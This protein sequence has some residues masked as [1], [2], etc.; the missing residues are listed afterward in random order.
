MPRSSKGVKQ[1]ECF[2]CDGWNDG[3][4]ANEIEKALRAVDLPLHCAC[5]WIHRK[6][7]ED[8]FESRKPFDGKHRYYAIAMYPDDEPVDAGNIFDWRCQF[9]QFRQEQEAK[10]LDAVFLPVPRTR[11]DEGWEHWLSSHLEE[12]LRF[13]DEDAGGG[14]ALRIRSRVV[15]SRTEGPLYD[16]GFLTISPRGA[17]SRT[18]DQL[19][20]ARARWRAATLGRPNERECQ[21][22]QRMVKTVLDDPQADTK[23]L[24]HRLIEF[25]KK[26]PSPSELPRILLLGE[27]GCGKSLIANYLAYIDGEAR[28][29][30]AYMRIP[31]P[32]YH[33]NEQHFEYSLLGYARGSYSGAE[34]GSCGCLLDMMG[35]VVFFDEVGDANPIIQ[36]KLL[37]FLDDYRV[38]PRGWP[39][40]LHPVPCPLLVVA[41]T[42]QPIDHWAHGR[43][44]DRHPGG[45]TTETFR[46]DLL[47]RFDVIVRVPSLRERTQEQELPYILDSILQDERINRGT[48]TNAISESALRT[49]EEWINRGD[50]DHGNFRALLKLMRA[51]CEYGYRHNE[52]MIHTYHLEYA[53]KRSLVLSGG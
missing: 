38:T 7:P 47:E 52:D 45:G 20:Y 44:D 4:D 23:T 16:P 5:L 35:K 42:N 39:D 15:L 22:V 51:T 8:L 33:G 37:A 27:S 53:R 28:N 46:R 26:C 40:G 14:E 24:Q 10:L 29:A 9:V 41:A 18:L 31:M 13:R 12:L 21:D 48:F 32:E 6:K 19:D 43:V 30:P 25:A 11:P 1:T 34:R 17:M 36:A 50:F 3:P 49:L 2:P